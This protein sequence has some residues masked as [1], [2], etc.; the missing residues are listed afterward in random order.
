MKT[1]R[2]LFLNLISFA[3]KDLFAE[4]SLSGPECTLTL[5]RED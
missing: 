4:V 1:E 5:S 2:Q 3:L